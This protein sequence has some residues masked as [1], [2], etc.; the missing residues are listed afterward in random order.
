ME[1]AVIRGSSPLS[2]GIRKPDHLPLMVDGIIPALAGNTSYISCG[3]HPPRDH[4]RSR[5]EYGPELTRIRPDLGSSPL[6]RGIRSE[7]SRRMLPK[8][9]IPA[10]AGNTPDRRHEGRIHRDHPRSRGE[11]LRVPHP[12]GGQQGSSPLSRGIPEGRRG[13]YSADRII[14]ALAGNTWSRSFCLLSG[15]D[16]P[17]SRGEYA[18]PGPWSPLAGGSSPLS[19]GILRPSCP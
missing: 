8:R 16:H 14:P 13:D 9:I 11:Y 17:R 3:V 6:S 7:G 5:G 1:T 2:R 12:D 10:L 18:D 19:R 4:P 15:W